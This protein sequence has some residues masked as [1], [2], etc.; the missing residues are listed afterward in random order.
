MEK[1]DPTHLTPDTVRQTRIR[2]I[3]LLQGCVLLFSA[4][5]VMLKLAGTAELLSLRCILFYG[6]GLALLGVYA[7]FWQRFLE[8]MPLTVAYANRAMSMCWSMIFGALLFGERIRP[9]MVIGVSVIAAGI[10]LMVTA[11]EE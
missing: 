10:I 4:S 2:D 8:R 9:G 3:L 7:L 6:A 1:P 5:S 11:D